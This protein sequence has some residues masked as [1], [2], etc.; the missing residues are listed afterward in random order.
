MK[1][2]K[3]LLSIL[4]CILTL[5][6]FAENYYT[7]IYEDDTQTKPSNYKDSSTNY[8]PQQTTE[9]FPRFEGHLLSELYFDA[10]TNNGEK[11][12]AGESKT[13][14]YLYL[15]SLMRL[16]IT[17]GFFAET[18]WYLEPVNDR[19]YTGDLYAANPGYIVG[20]ALNSDFYGR[21][22]HVKRR[23][24]SWS[25]GLGVETLNV[26]Y[27]NS[28]FAAAIGKINPTF[29]SAFD[30]SR[31]S[32][33]YGITLPEEYELTEKIGGYVSAI[34]P[35]GNITFNAFFDDT[36]ELSNT[37]FRHRGRDKSIGG[38]GN[39]EKLN[40]FS[41]T[42]DGKFDNL[43]INAGFRYLDVDLKQEDAEKGFVFGAEY[44]FEFPYN[45]N[46]LPFVEV[47]YFDNF[48]GMASRDVTY[49]TTFLPIII[50][51]WHFIA[52]NTSKFDDEK[53]YHSYTSHLTQLSIGYKFD[54]GLMIDV[55]RIWERSVKKADGFAGLGRRDK[56]VRHAD[57]WAFMVSY[58]FE[59]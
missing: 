8:K 44:L 49:L 18:K 4:L 31:F 46:F 48:D 22:N 47:A 58:L 14:T 34:L 10:Y 33:I 42:F 19:L 17:K 24:Q 25:Y 59:F 3:Y 2:V 51:N 55:A 45:I 37:M 1:K 32:G 16:R 54:F 7:D 52:S 15:E 13:N 30:K 29:G 57:S 27:R 38:A 5:P 41:I 50:E 28:N 53:G 9:S 35:F 26:G 40:N 6:A 43:S 11:I 36:S 56:W 12:Q 23:F 20:N 21:E 39:T